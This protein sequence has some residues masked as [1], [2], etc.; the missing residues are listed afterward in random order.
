MS[1]SCYRGRPLIGRYWEQKAELAASPCAVFLAAPLRFQVQGVRMFSPVGR[2]KPDRE[3]AVGR[4]N[5]IGDGP[6]DH[7]VA[8]DP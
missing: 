2:L 7:T 5:M 4:K 3:A 6:A 1:L 8:R